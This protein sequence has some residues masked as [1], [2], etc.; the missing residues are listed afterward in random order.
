MYF[1][2]DTIYVKTTIGASCPLSQIGNELI[3]NMKPRTDSYL[4]GSVFF[5]LHL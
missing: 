4:F 5:D 2:F 3:K 1:F